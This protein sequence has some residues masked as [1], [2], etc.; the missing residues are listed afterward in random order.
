MNFNFINWPITISIFLL[1]SI[2]ILVI[3]S[4]SPQLALQQAIFALIGLIC[5]FFMSKFDYRAVKNL[6]NPLY[7][8]LIILLVVVLI[9]GLVIRISSRWIAVGFINIQPSEFIKPILILFL[10]DFWSNNRL[11]WGNILKNL[12]WISPPL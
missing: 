2:G 9:I 10:A 12:L 7:I 5:Y 3:W 6:I 4:S 8:I 11:T 1:L